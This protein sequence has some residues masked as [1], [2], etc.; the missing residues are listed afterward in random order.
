MAGSLKAT[1]AVES[2]TPFT[3]LAEKYKVAYGV[4]GTLK[5]VGGVYKLLAF[6]VAAAG[7]VGGFTL[8]SLPVGMLALVGAVVFAAIL[9]GTGLLLQAIGETLGAVLDTAVNTRATAEKALEK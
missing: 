5:A 1:G 3:T 6:I 2:T 7:V 8:G 9:Y 4:G